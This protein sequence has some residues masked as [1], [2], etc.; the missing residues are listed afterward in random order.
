[1]VAFGANL[2]DRQATFHAADQALKNLGEVVATSPL[3]D[4]EALIHVD[5]P[6]ASYPSFLNGAWRLRTRLQ[7]RELLAALH[8]I[9]RELGRV[10]EPD[11]PPWRP[12][13]IDLDLICYGLRIAEGDLT[14]PH[15]EM[16]R[17]RFVLEPML[18]LWP[19][20]RHPQFGLT[21]EELLAAL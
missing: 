7:P 10:R 8:G 17:R 4:T 3:S 19:D 16:H 1:M 21:T 13:I 5:D 12:R 15:P 11:D 9:E 18:D 6:A 14:L 2:G 20:W